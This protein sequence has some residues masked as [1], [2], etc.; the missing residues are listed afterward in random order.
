[1]SSTVRRFRVQDAGFLFGIALH[2][3]LKGCKSA[4]SAESLIDTDYTRKSASVH[5]S[6]PPGG[7]TGF[8]AKYA[9]QLIQARAQLC[10]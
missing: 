8:S 3:G 2:L 6:D 5:K 1:M 4:E 10:A 9:R 7:K